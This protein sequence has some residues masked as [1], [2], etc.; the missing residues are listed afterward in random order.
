MLQYA[1]RD[2]G[3]AV[4]ELGYTFHLVIEPQADRQHTWLT[5]TRAVHEH[6][7][8]LVVLINHFRKEYAMSF[9]ETPV[10]TWVQDPVDAVFSRSTGESIGPLDFIC[11]YYRHRC[12]GEFNYPPDQYFSTKIPVSTRVFHD[13]QAPSPDRE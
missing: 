3:S 12:V 6:D 8:A 4:E 2:I 1:M 9:G 7:P 11:G 5:T 10:L 13:A